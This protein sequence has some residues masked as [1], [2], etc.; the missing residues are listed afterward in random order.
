VVY[1][2]KAST[3]ETE[4]GESLELEAS[5]ISQGWLVPGETLSRKT[6]K[7]KEKDTK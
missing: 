2:F 7:R 6:N 1:T 3:Q 4:L 5:L